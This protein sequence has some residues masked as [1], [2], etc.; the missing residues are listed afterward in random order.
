MKDK[1]NVPVLIAGDFNSKSASW[2][3]KRTDERGI[4]VEDFITE[5]NL[6]IL[7]RQGQQ[8]TFFT[9]N[10]EENLDLTGGEENLDLTGLRLNHDKND[11]MG[12]APN[13]NRQPPCVHWNGVPPGTGRKRDTQS[14][15]QRVK[16]FLN[17]LEN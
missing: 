6:F 16:K 11:E 5:N 12:S 14:A 10:G 9:E 13:R 3:T 7:N 8:F 1:P 2:F 17:K 4:Q 15:G